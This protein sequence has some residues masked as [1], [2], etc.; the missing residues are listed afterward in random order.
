MNR[1]LTYCM[2]LFATQLCLA[3]DNNTYQVAS[4]DATVTLTV[5]PG[6]TLYV[7]V[8]VN[9]VSYARTSVGLD[10]R[11]YGIIGN[12][13]TVQAV[14]HRHVEGEIKVIEGEQPS[15]YENYNEM[16]LDMGNF[17]LIC[18]AYND[19]VAWRMATRIDDENIIINN[20][21]VDF[22]FTGTPAVWFSE[23]PAAMNQWELSYVRYN[24]LADV[25][26]GKFS[27]N[28]MMIKY[29]DTGL[30]LTIIESDIDDFPGMFLESKAN[31]HLVGKYAHYPK[32][33][34]NG[35]IYDDQRVLTRHDYI[36]RTAGTREYP[37]R[38]IIVSRNDVELLNNDLIYKLADEQKLTDTSWI[39]GGKT[40]FDWLVDG[41]LE[42]VDFP[43]GPNHPRSLEIFKYWV[44]FCA[45]YGLEYMCCDAGWDE[46][47][48]PALCQYAAERNVKIFVWDFYNMMLQDE[49]RLDR[50]KKYGIAGIKVDFIARDDQL[51]INWLA[52]M[53][54]MTAKRQLLLLMHGCPKPTGLHRTYPNIISYEAVHGLENNKWDR[55]CNPTYMVEWPFLRMLGGAADATPGML[56]NCTYRRFTIKPTGR[57]DC[58]GTR[59]NGMAMYVVFH[60]TLGF[61]SDSPTEYAK[62]PEMMEWLKHVPTVWDETLPLAGEM[63]EYI[64]MARRKGNEWYVGAMN[65]MD[66]QHSQ[67]SRDIE[68]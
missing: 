33:T 49:E 27:V 26:A 60:Q 40:G 9:N 2:L 46:S 53:A 48:M 23:A 21:L 47:Y 1:L 13:A 12:G 30:G 20:E 67:Y 7:S 58:T 43:N 66:E 4:P 31:G 68:I 34:N 51:A 54:E 14:E 3:N 52:Q 32:T 64:I 65:K 5:A 25:P 59:A 18:R 15:I 29:E 50:F 6:D 17:D 38:G 42:G 37:W 11:R 35:S 41:V 8:A 24:S 63:S 36:A 62:E 16:I 61:V 57:P 22:T 55:T 19:G 39:K 44:D 10:T 56:S 45:E 28:P